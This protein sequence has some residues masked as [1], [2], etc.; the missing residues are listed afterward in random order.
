VRGVNETKG[1]EVAGGRLA[2]LDKKRLASLI[3]N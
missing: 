2:S 3:V 1:A